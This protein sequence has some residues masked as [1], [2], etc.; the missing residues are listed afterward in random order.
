MEQSQEL[1]ILL[2]GTLLTFLRRPRTLRMDR[3]ATPIKPCM[4]LSTSRARVVI[5]T[6]KWQER[7]A[8]WRMFRHLTSPQIRLPHG[9]QHLT[10]T[11]EPTVPDDELDLN[12]QCPDDQLLY[13][14]SF[15]FRRRLP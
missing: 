6:N 9:V 11:L 12:N 2:P 3:L 8:P 13:F 4:K 14:S 15:L 10:F 7:L 5:P 1:F